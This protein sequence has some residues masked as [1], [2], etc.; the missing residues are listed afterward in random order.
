[1]ARFFLFFV[2]FA[3]TSFI[4]AQHIPQDVDVVTDTIEI[5]MEGPV[6]KKVG[7]FNHIKIENWDDLANLPLLKTKIDLMVKA[8]EEWV[9]VGKAEIYRFKEKEKLVEIKLLEDLKPPK[10]LSNWSLDS[11]SKV[12]LCW[13]EIAEQ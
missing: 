13:K 3:L 7:I 4:K 2:F 12:R 8:S 6:V 11:K 1:M 5:F 10:G 9:V